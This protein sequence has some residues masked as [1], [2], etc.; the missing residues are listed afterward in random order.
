[1]W[2]VLILATL[3]RRLEQHGLGLNLFADM[4]RCSIHELIIIS[5]TKCGNSHTIPWTVSRYRIWRHILWPASATLS[6]SNYRE[7][8]SE[9]RS[10][11][12]VAC[13]ILI[14]IRHR[15]KVWMRHTNFRPSCDKNHSKNWVVRNCQRAHFHGDNAADVWLWF[16]R[17][18]HIA[19]S[20][21]VLERCVIIPELKIAC[22][23]IIG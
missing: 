23:I 9:C 21:K 20:C 11:F 15:S 6:A 22:N 2:I 12:D 14:S 7:F 17:L 18:S 5:I 10:H 8:F 3:W 4:C 19:L 16:F 13:G 1:M